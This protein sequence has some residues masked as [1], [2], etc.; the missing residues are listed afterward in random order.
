LGYGFSMFGKLHRHELYYIVFIIW[1]LQLIL[2]PIWLGYFRFGPLEWL[3]RSLT[4]WQKQP[5]RRE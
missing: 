2:S 3:W 4:Y 1:L 5:F